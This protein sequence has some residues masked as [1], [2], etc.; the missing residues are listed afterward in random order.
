LNIDIYNEFSD[1]LKKIWTEFEEEININSFQSFDW[2]DNWQKIIGKPLISTEPQIVHIYNHEKTFAIFPLAIN[3]KYGINILEWI[4]GVN[5]DY[6][7]P[8]VHSELKSVAK[9]EDYWNLILSKIGS[10]DLI[11]FQKQNEQT[12][13][14]L[15]YLGFSNENHSL[16]LK[17]YNTLLAEDWDQHYK[18]IKKRIRSDSERQI[19]RL[20]KIDTINFDIAES[21]SDKKY[22]IEKMIEQK[23]NRYEK[24]KV[25]NMFK[26]QHY[27]DFYEKL[28]YLDSKRFQVHCSSLKVGNEII[29][30]HVGIYNKRIFYYLMPAN[31]FNEWEK[32]SPGRLL[33]I[34]LLE[35]SVKNKLSMFDFTVGGETY[36]KIWCD[37]EINLYYSLK[38]ITLKGKIYCNFLNMK[39]QIKKSIFLSGIIR[40]MKSYVS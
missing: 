15:N 10:F 12:V 19:R 16:Y 33:L 24:T 7:G 14:I 35:W 2:L 11:H 5:T 27:K 28:A 6:M 29:A 34:K 40:K 32:F 37:Q 31:N 18:T 26:I 3:K 17:A 4:G 39:L 23:Y 30:T 13:S 1:I 8:L 38:A 36:K 9:F 20:K 21:I 25:W 22:I